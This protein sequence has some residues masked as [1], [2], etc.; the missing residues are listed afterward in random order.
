M[1]VPDEAAGEILAGFLESRA[2]E[3]IWEVQAKMRHAAVEANLQG[4]QTREYWQGYVAAIAELRTRVTEIARV[5]IE[6]D[7]A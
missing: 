1:S 6:G 2:S 4:A 5:Y 7:E 3:V